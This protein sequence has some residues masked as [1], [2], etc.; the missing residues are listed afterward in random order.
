MSKIDRDMIINLIKDRFISVKEVH[1]YWLEGADGLNAVD[2]YSDIDI[3]LDVEDGYEDKIFQIAEEEFSKLGKLDFKFNV[4]HSH[5]KIHQNYYHIEGSSE[6]LIIDFCIQSHSR[7]KD[8]VRFVEGDI[9][10]FPKVI[11]DKS[12]VITIIKDY[13]QVDINLMQKALDEIRSKYKQHSRV[14]KYV[15]RK[16]YLEAF[17]YY[18]KYVADPLVELVR[19]KYTPKYFDLHLIHISNHIPEKD[20]KLLEYYYQ[21]SSLNDI[22]VKTVEAKEVCKKLMREIGEIYKLK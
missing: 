9:L 20:R 16:N 11:F 4:D 3:W 6:Y 7:D 19:L 12:G 8:E 15:E 17:I 5:P 21:I 22:Q 13:E 10:E 14:L 18:L 2:K 1:A